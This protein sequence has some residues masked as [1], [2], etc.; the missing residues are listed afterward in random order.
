MY[1][2][3]SYYAYLG[4]FILWYRRLD[5]KLVL[6]WR[7]KRFF[8]LLASITLFGDFL[9]LISEGCETLPL[10]LPLLLAWLLST[11]IVV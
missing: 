7:V 5:K 11:G 9:C 2:I 1:A 8:I 3:R 10:F 4:L 6:T